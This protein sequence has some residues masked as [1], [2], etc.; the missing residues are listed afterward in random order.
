MTIWARIWGHCLPWRWE[1][2]L[3]QGF[4]GVIVNNLNNASDAAT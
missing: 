2:L 4:R 1:E 3:H